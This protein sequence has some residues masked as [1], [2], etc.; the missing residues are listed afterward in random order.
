MPSE[1]CRTIINTTLTLRPCK[2]VL[3][4]V[5]ITLDKICKCQ[6]KSNVRIHL[7]SYSY[8]VLGS[9]QL[10]FGLLR[11]MSA[12]VAAKCSTTTSFAPLL[13]VLSRL[14]AVVSYELSLQTNYLNSELIGLFLL[15]PCAY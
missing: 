4:N 6:T 3:V 10:C 1:G 5:L 2:D 9:M 11:E 7:G 15:E 13:L 12:S 14:C 8:A